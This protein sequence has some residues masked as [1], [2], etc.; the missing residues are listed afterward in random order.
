MNIF[1]PRP[2]ACPQR[3]PH[4]GHSAKPW[5][6]NLWGKPASHLFGKFWGECSGK[7]R[8]KRHVGFGIKLCYYRLWYL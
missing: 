8:A 4:P 6:F 5:Y 7:Y 3:D 1:S 2:A